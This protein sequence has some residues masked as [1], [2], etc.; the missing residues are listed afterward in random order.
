MLTTVTPDALVPRSHPIRR[1]KPDGEQR[2]YCAV[3]DVQSDVL[4]TR[5]VVNTSGTSSEGLSADGVVLS[6]S[7]AKN[8]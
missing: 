4:R 2:P 5:S 1:I 3:S 8:C 6:V 7:R